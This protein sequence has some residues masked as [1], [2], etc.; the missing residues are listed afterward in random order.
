MVPM[1]MG[2][3]NPQRRATPNLHWAPPSLRELLLRPPLSLEEGR[4]EFVEFV[5]DLVGFSFFQK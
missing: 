2:N 1:R 5:T 4:E 3:K